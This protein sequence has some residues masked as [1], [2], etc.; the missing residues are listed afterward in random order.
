MKNKDYLDEWLKIFLTLNEAQKRWAAALKS[1]ESGYGGITKISRITGLSRTTITKGLEEL[2]ALTTPLQDGR[3]RETGGGR[4]R[5]ENNNDIAERIEKILEETTG[6]DPMNAL[7]WTYKS[8][9]KI[10]GELKK[11]GIDISHTKAGQILTDNDYTLQTNRKTLNNCNRLYRNEQFEYI[12]KTVRNFFE[13]GQPVISADAEKRE[14]AG[15]FKNNGKTWRKKKNPKKV[16]DHDFASLGKGIAIPYGAYDIW[17]N[18]GFVNVGISSDTA[19]FAVG[20]ID[21]WR[22]LTGKKRY[23]DAKMLLICCDG[24]GSNGHRNKGWKVY[25]QRLADKTEKDIM[26]CHYPPGTGKWNKTEHKMFSFIS[27]NRRGVPLE[28]YETVINLTGNTTTGKGL[29][30][31]AAPDERI[32]EKG[33][34]FSDDDIANINLYPHDKFPK[35][36]YTIK[37]NK[38]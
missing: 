38:T 10:A 6:G 26:I 27:L 16:N 12:N 9:R 2:D 14:P 32:Y 1:K 36:N 28:N 23:S 19:E 29:K 31:K 25:L 8:A 22:G 24:G 17:R 18:E 37:Y 3:I 33:K 4:K 15:N 13:S 20:S 34:R 7:K 35:W 30:I 21:Q 5:M 11:Q